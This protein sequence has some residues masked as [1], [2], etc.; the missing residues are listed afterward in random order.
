MT[1]I[2]ARTQKLLD[3]PKALCNMVAR[4]A[5]AAGDR[6]LD[7]YDESGSGAFETKADGSVVTQADREAEE[8]IRTRLAD[9]AS[10]IPFIG[11][12]TVAAGTC[13]PLTDGGW[14]W[15]VDPIDGTRGFIRGNPDYTVNIA[16]IH[17]GA[18]VLGVVYVPVTGTLYAGC[19][20]GTAIR[21]IEGESAQDKPIAVRP[22]PARG[23]TVLESSYHRSD[24]IQTRFL[25]SLKV[26]KRIRRGSSLKICL[27]AAGKAD[28]YPRLG[29]TSE[30]DTAAADAVLRAAG[31]TIVDLNGNTL[32]YGHAEREFRNPD[33]VA[34]SGF[35]PVGGG[36]EVL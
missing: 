4:I 25:D 21:R 11:E 1:V 20:P 16:L 33:F 29:E 35:W 28:L 9:I 2:Q 32:T 26:E 13:P 18:P 27:I 8:I 17:N 23:L 19:G 5:V 31:G 15:L 14:F 10:D 24:E 34:S 3:H 7:Y 36:D 30:W 22:P 6:T 12:E